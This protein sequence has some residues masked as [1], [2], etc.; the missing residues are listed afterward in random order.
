MDFRHS[1]LFGFET[2]FWSDKSEIRTFWSDFRHLMCLKIEHTNVWI[3]DIHCIVC[4]LNIKKKLSF[5][6]VIMLI[7][8]LFSS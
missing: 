4:Y 5:N 3:S 2:H 1:K 7:Y 6:Y 8:F